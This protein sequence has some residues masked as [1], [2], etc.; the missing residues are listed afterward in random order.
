MPHL[1]N[2]EDILRKAIEKAEANGFSL[3]DWCG[4]KEDSFSDLKGK[5]AKWSL[6][7][8]VNYRMLL[9]SHDFAKAFWGE[10]DKAVVQKGGVE[11]S[12]EQLA[13]VWQYH[14]QQLVLE[15]DPINYLASFL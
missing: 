13:P 10:N 15:P 7:D 9:F 2:K 14:L 6:L 5:F 1:Q 3:C 8:D 4:I 11:T 12:S